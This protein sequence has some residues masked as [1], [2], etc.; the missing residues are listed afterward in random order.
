MKTIGLV[1]SGG[2]A[3]AYAHIG[4]LQALNEN[5]IYP[6][7][8]SGASAGALVGGLY[9]HGY[10]PLQILALSKSDEFLKIFKIGL[11][12]RELTEMTRLKSFLHK[13]I[14]DDF[15]FLKIPLS[16]AVTNLNLGNYEIKSSGKLI[17]VIAASC[18]IPI[19]FRAVKIDEYLYVDGGL[20]NNLPIEPLLGITDK[21]IGVSIN[22]HEYKDT[23]KGRLKII[24][25]CLQLAVWN[26]TQERINKCDVSILIDKHVNFNMFSIHKSQE[27][28]DIGYKTAI[29]QMD[30]ILKA[31][32]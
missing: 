2:G 26:T 31:I 15:K 12:N 30:T 27:L 29:D 14:Q 1:L 4:V 3:R 11:I 13:H 32:E 7:H 19:L 9:C 18:A 24:E 28:F 23:I 8:I 17:S 16:V 25:R 6:T 21:I 10:T 22:E 5:G 20:L